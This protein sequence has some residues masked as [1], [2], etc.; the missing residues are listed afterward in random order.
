MYVKN[1]ITTI[2]H[3]YDG[4]CMHAMQYT[5]SATC[6][7]LS[8]EK[9]ALAHKFSL[10]ISNCYVRRRQEPQPLYCW[11]FIHRL[12]DVRSFVDDSTIFY[13][14]RVMER[15]AHIYSQIRLNTK[16]TSIQLWIASKDKNKH[17]VVNIWTLYFKSCACASN[18]ATKVCKWAIL[19]F[20]DWM[21]TKVSLEC[22]LFSSTSIRSDFF[23]IYRNISRESLNWRHKCFGFCF[24]A[25]EREK[26]DLSSRKRCS[27]KV[28]A[29]IDNATAAV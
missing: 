20:F 22:H 4:C 28:L 9:T 13:T 19:F 15:N 21:N 8:R 5:Y 27:L 3:R 16:L 7:A 1:N 26:F 12:F 23:L 14:H 2:P 17:A 29:I 24:D 25:H 6:D 18:S 10:F 11:Q